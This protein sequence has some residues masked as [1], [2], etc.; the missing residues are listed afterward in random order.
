M[1]GGPSN[2]GPRLRR[3]LAVAGSCAVACVLFRE[4]WVE[5][6]ATGFGDYQEYHHLWEAGWVA[7][8]RFGEL[9]LWNP[10]QCGGITQYGNPQTQ[11]FHPL[12]FVS[13]LI[14]T[15]FA[16]K[17][18]L[19]LHAAAGVLGGYLLA[20][21]EE[22]LGVVASSM[23]AI[24]WAGS[25]YFAWHCGT[26]HANFIAFYLLPWLVWCWRRS[27]VDV[28]WAVGTGLV[29]S[30]VVFAGGVY[31]FPFFVLVLAHESL[32]SLGERQRRSN[33]LS[34]GLLAILITVLVGA[35]RLLPILADLQHHPRLA[36]SP[37]AMTLGDL[38]TAM[39][40]QDMRWPLEIVPGHRWLWVE[41]SAYVGWTV[42]L[43]G[44]LGLGLALKRRRRLHLVTGTLVF[45]VLTLGSFADWAPWSLVH[46]LPIF[47]SLRVPSRF[48]VI[49]LFY[50][51]LLAAH[52]LESIAAQARRA[53][54][55][56]KL[57]GAR[58]VGLATAL[59]LAG[60]ACADV[61]ATHLAG[62]DG[63]W[64]DPPIEGAR[65]LPHFLA[66]VPGPTDWPGEDIHPTPA[67]FPR[68]NIGTGYCYSGMHYHGARGLWPGW[69]EQV[70]VEPGDGVVYEEHISANTVSA[71]VEV[72]RAGR[73]VFNRTWA[74]DWTATQGGVERTALDLM[75]VPLPPGMHRVELRYEPRTLPWGFAGTLLGVLLAAWIL[76]RRLRG[77][78]RN[79][80]LFFAGSAATLGGY[81]FLLDDIATEPTAPAYAV[82]ASDWA[83]RELNDWYVPEHVSDGLPGTEWHL[84]GPEV[85]WLELRAPE[86]TSMAW[87]R[88]LNAR[89][90]PHFDRGAERVR[91]TAIDGEA[92]VARA[93]VTLDPPGEEIAWRDVYLG[94]A[95]ASLLRIEV[96]SA[97]GLSGGLAEVE[98]VPA[99]VT[100]GPTTSVSASSPGAGEAARRAHDGRVDTVWRAGE[101]DLAPWLELRFQVP[102]YVSG[103]TLVAPGG[104]EPQTVEVIV[105]GEEETLA[106]VPAVVASGDSATST[107]V[108]IHRAGVTWLRVRF[109]G[110]GAALAESRVF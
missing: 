13:L 66:R 40:W 84:P 54:T 52:G 14:G 32:W 95:R 36:P 33:V 80:V 98:V 109:E 44:L 61:G 31:A 63:K 105:G 19:I 103:L 26:G 69:R 34:A 82:R 24:A 2:P 100:Y 22:G 86:P 78:R 7:L 17:L 96:L 97:Y 107:D 51:V 6:E 93:E 1:V 81:F 4:V 56:R 25:G 67:Y 85:G 12:F 106:I 62:L 46:E 28:R 45:G 21:R 18:F 92:V 20:R 50:F 71:L 110:P 59:A 90:A 108:S 91:L 5:P 74:P 64:R 87:V 43:L 75:A 37:D 104:A 55:E 101:G 79:A 38:V 83:E 23:A 65:P 70:R 30:L 57:R 94:A 58:W 76:R 41:Y 11:V 49:F 16:L 35:L 89:N 102:H 10:H 99:P 27:T 8:T 15:T 48:S 72:P 53:A 39:V 68:L 88:L 9:P 29:M 3:W 42:L 47:D 60:T 77:G 73:A